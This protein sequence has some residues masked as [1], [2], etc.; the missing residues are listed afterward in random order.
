MPAPQAESDSNTDVPILA[1]GLARIAKGKAEA[2]KLPSPPS[3]DVLYVN[4]PDEQM[5]EY[6][7][8]QWEDEVYEVGEPEEANL[9][10]PAVS[11]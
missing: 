10:I 9:N 7:R 1:V 5:P 6:Q 8:E 3:S 11:Q 4:P 2:Q